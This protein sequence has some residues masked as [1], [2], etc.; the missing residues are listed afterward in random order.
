MYFLLIL[1]PKADKEALKQSQPLEQV[2]ILVNC[3]NLGFYL[4]QRNYGMVVRRE[5]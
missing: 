1:N 3:A 4:G 5:K 2:S